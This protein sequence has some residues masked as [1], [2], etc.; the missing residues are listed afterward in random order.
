MKRTPPALRRSQ[1]IF[2]Q[3]NSAVIRPQV[4]DNNEQSNQLISSI[5]QQ[6]DNND[7]TYIVPLSSASLPD[8]HMYQRFQDVMG[9]DRRSERN[10]TNN[11][12]DTFMIN[13][14]C[15]ENRGDGSHV[16]HSSSINRRRL[17]I[18]LKFAKKKQEAII[19]ALEIQ[20]QF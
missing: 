7:R 20:E 1:R 4:G 8:R 9:N 10:P 14:T 2:N 12:L 11:N 13:E 16:S 17:E 5:R 6:N 15:R 3:Q 18:Q 19:R